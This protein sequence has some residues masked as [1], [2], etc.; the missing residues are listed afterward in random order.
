[1]YVQNSSIHDMSNKLCGYYRYTKASLQGIRVSVRVRLG[2]LLETGL[3]PILAVY[4]V[5]T[6]VIRK[7][8]HLASYRLNKIFRMDYQSYPS[9]T[10]EYVNA[11]N[12]S[13]SL[14]LVTTTCF[15]VH[16][17]GHSEA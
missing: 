6:P 14:E 13:D 10:H 15:H 8:E 12:I 3:V 17:P 11:G 9:I 5:K 4:H 16:T 2:Y 7:E 1:M